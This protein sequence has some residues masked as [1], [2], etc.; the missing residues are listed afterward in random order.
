[1]PRRGLG[2]HL[3]RL[4]DEAATAAGELNPKTLLAARPPGG[5][6]HRDILATLALVTQAL[7]DV[8]RASQLTGPSS[9]FM[10]PIAESGE[11]K[12]ATDD[13]FLG[14]IRQW[15]QEQRET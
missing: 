9:P 3:R 6:D 10:H 14:P 8:R 13:R 15:E 2:S 4:W 11:R 5:C 12:S 1:M 7:A